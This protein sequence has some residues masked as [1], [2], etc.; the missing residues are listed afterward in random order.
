MATR[1]FST[2]DEERSIHR[3]RTTQPG[4]LFAPLR[5]KVIQ[6]DGKTVTLETHSP[7]VPVTITCEWGADMWTECPSSLSGPTKGEEGDL[8]VTKKFLD[9]HG[10]IYTP[11]WPDAR[12]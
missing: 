8:Y 12:G 7:D 11:K 3:A 10:L 6:S 4:V 5:V 1:N 2:A 9:Q